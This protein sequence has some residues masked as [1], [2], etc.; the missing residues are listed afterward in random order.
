MFSNFKF[1]KSDTV[2]T[3]TQ[4]LKTDTK[5]DEQYKDPY[6]PSFKSINQGLTRHQSSL[7]I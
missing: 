5:K 1:G 3:F 6:E 4:L 2:K 7:S